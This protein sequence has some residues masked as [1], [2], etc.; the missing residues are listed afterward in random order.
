MSI[1][2]NIEVPVLLGQMKQKTVSV[3]VEL[4][5]VEALKEEYVCVV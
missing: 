2:P 1:M 4:W 3:S 5:R